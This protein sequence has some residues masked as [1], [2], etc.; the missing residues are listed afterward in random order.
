MVET[1]P[2][3]YIPDASV[4]MK[5]ILTEENDVAQARQLR[6]DFARGT[7]QLEV[8]DHFYAEIMNILS[9]H[10][11]DHALRFFSQLKMSTL[12][13]NRLSIEVASLGHDLIQKYPKISF[14]DAAYHAL[15][16]HRQGTFI[17]ADERYHTMTKKEGAI[18]LLKDYE[19]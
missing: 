5:W 16:L 17:T 4:V 14:Y 11:P 8:P 19:S 6:D 13:V 18:L 2:P 9:R 12:I 10:C 3:L 1:N 7:I 15:A